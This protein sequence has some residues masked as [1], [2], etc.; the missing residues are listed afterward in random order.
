M[1]TPISNQVIIKN[2]EKTEKKVGVLAIPDTVGNREKTRTGV[3]VS[4]G[5]GLVLTTGERLPNA[6]QPGDVVVFAQG[7]IFKYEGE[8]YYL[9]RDDMIL[10]KVEQDEAAV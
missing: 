3:V 10:A 5:P 6:A 7:G 9:V 4:T 8:E 1:L 2:L